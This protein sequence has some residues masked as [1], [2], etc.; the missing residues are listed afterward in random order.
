MVEVAA[1]DGESGWPTDGFVRPGWWARGGGGR[2]GGVETLASRPAVVRSWV[3]GP[4]AGGLDRVVGGLEMG[5]VVGC[6]V[7]SFGQG[8]VGVRWWLGNE[9]AGSNCWRHVRRSYLRAFWVQEWGGLNCVVGLVGTD[10]GRELVFNNCGGGRWQWLYAMV[11]ELETARWRC[12]CHV[13]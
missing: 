6:L 10:W 9:T 7:R 2:D 3:L 13:W 4:R 12:W 1:K 11:V 5:E 8:E